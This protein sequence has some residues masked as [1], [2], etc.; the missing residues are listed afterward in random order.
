MGPYQR[1][2]VIMSGTAAAGGSWAEQFRAV[3]AR[4]T[5]P[6]EV[7]RRLLGD[8][9][10][11][12]LAD[13]A[14]AGGAVLVADD[15]RHLRYLVAR[16]AGA[17][18]LAGVRVPIEGSIAGYVFSTGSM[19]ALG[20]LEGEQPPD[21]YEELGRQLGAAPHAYLALP[22]LHGG[23]AQGVAAY[24]NRTGPP[25]APFRQEEME[26]ARQYTVLQGAVLRHLE[27]LWQLDRFGA[28]DLAVA[29]AALDPAGADPAA[30][31]PAGPERHLEPWARML[32][33]LER[34]S[35]EDQDF[36]SDLVAFVARRRNWEL[37]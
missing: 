19:M 17:D 15:D 2:D 25:Q 1:E 30:T 12:A 7:L 34:L 32:Q 18:R 36:C 20:R 6:A 8:I 3:A 21:L 29:W 24:V 28:Y 27:R 4:M 16:G 10:D 11:R 23:R 13:I 26:R 14:A 22:I 5:E 35:Q 33:H 9:I 37:G 31:R